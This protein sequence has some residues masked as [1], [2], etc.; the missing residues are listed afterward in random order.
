[1]TISPYV[2][3]LIAAVFFGMTKT[4]VPGCGILGVLVM[5]LAFPGTEKLSS[6]AVLPLLVLGDIIAVWYYRRNADCRRIVILLPSVFAGLILGTLFMRSIDDRQFK[7]F[8]AVLVLVLVIFEQL[9]R[10]QNWTALPKSRLFV[11]SMG[12]LS[13]FT[14]LVGNAAGPVMSVYCSAQNL[15]KH[16][17]MGLFAVLFFIINV[18][19]L[20][21]IGGAVPDLN[22]IT[23]RTLWF[24]V[25]I[26]PG[27]LVGAFIG[28]QL[29]KIVPERYFVP[30]ILLLN[31]LVPVQMIF[32]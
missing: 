14:T 4:G 9:R 31:L 6:G 8:L 1:M 27:L 30:L 10:W 7:I 13:G 19:K 22:M 11:W 16:D 24:D 15:N 29:F 3:G 25:T 5:M 2:F 32:F 26:L 18:T 17:F 28:R 21:L 23:A 12:L 20:P